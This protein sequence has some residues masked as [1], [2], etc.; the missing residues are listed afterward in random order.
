MLKTIND[1]IRQ[2]YLR[3]KNLY[4]QIIKKVRN[5]IHGAKPNSYQIMFQPRNFWKKV[6]VKKQYANPVKSNDL[7][8]SELFTHLNFF[9]AQIRTIEINLQIQ[10]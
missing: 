4:N 6:K 7:Y 8:N 3:S 9:I 10:H 1:N 2:Q 5:Y